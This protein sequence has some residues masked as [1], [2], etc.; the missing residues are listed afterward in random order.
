[1]YK[2]K[3]KN[4]EGKVIYGTDGDDII[5]CNYGDTVYAGKGD[6]TII[7]SSV[8]NRDFNLK[9]QKCTYIDGEGGDDSIK[10]SG[11]SSNVIIYG[12]VG[13]DSISA[14]K[15]LSKATIHGGSGADTIK[16]SGKSS[17]VIIEQDN[18]DTIIRQ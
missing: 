10:L 8:N 11:K 2:S 3:K 17:N 15:E 5:H 18:E 14:G 16:L 1:M 13:D 4:K 9:S 12:G 7:C 6:D